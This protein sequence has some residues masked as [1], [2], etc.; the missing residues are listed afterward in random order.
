MSEETDDMYLIPEGYEGDVYIFYNVKGAHPL[1]QEDEYDVYDVN[2]EGYFVTSTADMDYGTVTD[3]YYYIDKSGKRTKI[4]ES[5]V[6]GMGTGE[7]QN[8][9]NSKEVIRIRYTGVEVTRTQCGTKFVQSANG[10]DHD[11]MELVLENVVEKY[12]GQKLQ[13]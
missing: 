4:D 8:D 10:I 6:R 13:R 5:C 1:K 2:D 9:P 12:Y 11:Q 7:F 3:R